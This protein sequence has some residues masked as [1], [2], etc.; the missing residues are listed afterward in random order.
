MRILMVSDVYFPRVN[1]VSTSI[2]TFREEFL[3]MGHEVTL[4]AP[5]YPTE[6]EENAAI[7]LPSRGVPRDPED[8]MIRFG[9]ALRRLD[10]IGEGDYDLVH[11]HTP[12]VAHYLGRKL[13]RRIGAPVVE[14]YHTFFEEY[15]YHYVPLL[16]KG[17]LRRL[18]RF[19]SRVQC[20][21]V[22][23]VVV[24]SH[25]M[26]DT[27]SRY[28]VTTPMEIIPTGIPA[29]P[30]EDVDGGAFRDRHA[31]P[32]DI[33]LLL[34]VGRVAHEK[35]IDFL[36]RVVA[37]LRQ[38]FPKVLLLVTGEGPAGKHL[39]QLARRLGIADN[40]RFLGYLDRHRQLPACYAAADIFVFS[41]TTE[42]QGLVLLEA[43][44][45][46]TPVVALARLG[47]RDILAPGKGGIAAEEDEADFAAKVSRLL[48]DPELRH[49]MGEEGKE[50]VTTWHAPALA[51]RLM[52][53]Y[54]A[55]L[56]RRPVV[57]TTT[58]A[59]AQMS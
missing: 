18:A 20:N 31:I 26:R 57:P 8:R 55:T 5:E 45:V 47:T 14:T 39:H 6:D 53:F 11:I 38:D 7:R 44:T 54:Q 27:L 37:R 2:K 29:S 40:I 48:S 22:D 15:L 32:R 33:P 9:A 46:G 28:G 23:A 52:A 34:Y 35:N 50:Y 3:Q 43:M 17:S 21:E 1:G 36:L 49:R 12:F 51:E 13:A 4:L 58:Q 19:A 41:S 59:P 25:A 30:W 24:P 10:F 16:P 56:H 42:T